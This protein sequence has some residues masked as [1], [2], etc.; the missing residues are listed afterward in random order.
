MLEQASAQCDFLLVLLNSD[1]SATRVKRKPVHD[2]DL[3]A[4]NLAA[5]P[6]VDAVIRFEA[7][8][9]QAEI[10]FLAPDV[11]FKGPEHK[12]RENEI[13]GAASV[14]GRG[15]KVITTKLEYDTHASDTIAKA[16]SQEHPGEEAAPRAA[17]ASG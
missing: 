2:Y 13:P 14:L 12:G 6:A 1:E 8:T 11:L 7:D 9:P 4:A 10:D 15:G 5:L 16:Q 17:D 3:R